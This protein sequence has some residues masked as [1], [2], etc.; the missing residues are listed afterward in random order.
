M[1]TN[2]RDVAVEY[3]PDARAM[4]TAHCRHGC[5]RYLLGNARSTVFMSSGKLLLSRTQ[6]TS[7]RRPPWAGAAHLG[8]SSVQVRLAPNEVWCRQVLS[9]RSFPAH[10]LCEHLLITHAARALLGKSADL[11]LGPLRID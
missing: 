10:A 11:E 9:F 6:E 8:D 5:N 1:G 3:P 7:I 4:L 2:C